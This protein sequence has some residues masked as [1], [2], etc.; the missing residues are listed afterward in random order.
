M[1]YRWA[2]WP[3]SRDNERQFLMLIGFNSLSWLKMMALYLYMAK[4]SGLFLLSLIFLNA[5]LP[6]SVGIN[7]PIF[8][9]PWRRWRSRSSSCGVDPTCSAFCAYR[10]PRKE[11][12][13]PRTCTYMDQSQVHLLLN[14]CPLHLRVHTTLAVTYWPSVQLVRATRN[15]AGHVY[16]ITNLELT[17]SCTKPS[18][19]CWS[20]CLGTGSKANGLAIHGCHAHVHDLTTRPAQMWPERLPERAAQAQRTHFTRI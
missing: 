18:T 7:L 13:P 16:K 8:G 19:S 6:K 1:A 5:T 15:Q 9:D 14:R 10:R 11:P 12:S 2:H 20:K 4:V 3:S 17:L